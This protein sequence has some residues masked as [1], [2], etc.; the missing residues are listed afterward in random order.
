MT[1]VDGI[2][3]QVQDDDQVEMSKYNYCLLLI[4]YCLLLIAYCLLLI[5]YC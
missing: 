2:L 1:A 4:A 5:A 3:K